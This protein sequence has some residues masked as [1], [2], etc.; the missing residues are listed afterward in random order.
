L[1]E[2]SYTILDRNR[3]LNIIR[4]PSRAEK[5]N[6]IYRIKPDENDENDKNDENGEMIKIMKMMKMVK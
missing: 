2:E 1:P 4:H 6:V 3:V 5:E